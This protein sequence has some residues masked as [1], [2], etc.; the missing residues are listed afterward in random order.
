MNA[1]LKCATALAADDFSGEWVAPLVFF[2]FFFNSFFLAAQINDSL[3]GFKILVADNGIMMIFQQVLI[4]LA[5]IDIAVSYLIIMGG[6]Y[7]IVS[8]YN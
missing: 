5:T 2:I 4:P 3:S 7:W 6:N 1:S 8:N